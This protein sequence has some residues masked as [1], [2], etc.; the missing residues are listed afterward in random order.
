MRAVIIGH[1]L[2]A[3]GA[4]GPQSTVCLIR[5]RA[6]HAGSSMHLRAASTE[7]EVRD[8]RRSAL[9]HGFFITH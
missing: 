2:T 6:L 3:G 5:D 8:A 1:T 9:T 4:P 7:H